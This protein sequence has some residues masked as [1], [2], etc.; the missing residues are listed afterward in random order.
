M[1]S[2]HSITLEM[3]ADHIGMMLMARSCYN[4][5][6]AIEFWEKD[7]NNENILIPERYRTHP[8]NDERARYLHEVAPLAQREFEKAGCSVR[9]R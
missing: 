5:N 9:V 1:D 8:T 2:N 6:M 3:E 4:P 7:L